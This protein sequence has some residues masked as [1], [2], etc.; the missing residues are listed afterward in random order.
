MLNDKALLGHRDLSYG[1]ESSSASVCPRLLA[2]NI[3]MN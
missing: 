2:L 3:S 1:F